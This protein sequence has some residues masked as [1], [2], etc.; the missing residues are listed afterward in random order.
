MWASV[1]PA[2]SVFLLTFVLLELGFLGPKNCFGVTSQPQD[3]PLN[4]RATAMLEEFPERLGAVVAGW[5]RV[6][7]C[8]GNFNSDNCLAPLA[9]KLPKSWEE[10]GR[11][12]L[13]SAGGRKAFPFIFRSCASAKGAL[14]VLLDG[15][16]WC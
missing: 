2:P 1:C 9:R 8:Q 3:A 12:I 14:A 16:L 15:G 10:T 7:F 11:I 13:G 4:V 6:G 5:L